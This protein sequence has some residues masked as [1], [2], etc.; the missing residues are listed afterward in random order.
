MNRLKISDKD[1]N[2]K[3]LSLGDWVLFDP[4]I[5]DA[6]RAAEISKIIPP[7]SIEFPDIREPI[8]HLYIDNDP[9]PWARQFSELQKISK[10]EAMIWILENS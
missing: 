3:K 6:L 7:C 10:E 1:K 2:G 5:H 8:A 9:D 4:G